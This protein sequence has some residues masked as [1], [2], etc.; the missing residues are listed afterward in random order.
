MKRVLVFGGAGFI[1]SYICRKLIEKGVTPIAFDSFAL[2]LSSLNPEELD[3]RNRAQKDRFEGIRDKLIP[4][5]GNATNYR[6][7]QRAIKIYDPDSII[8]L[9]GMPL[10]SA[11]NE[12]SEVSMEG[13]TSTGTIIQAIKDSG[14]KRKFIYT[15]SSTVYGDFGEEPVKEDREK[16]GK[17]IYA[18]VKLAGED[19]TRYF[20]RQFDIPYIII[21]P[22][23]VYGP[24]DINK[25]VVQKFI[26]GAIS[27]E[28]IVVNDPTSAI[29]FTYAKDAAQGFVLATLNEG[30]QDEEFNIS[31]GQG[32]TLEELLNIVRGHFPDMRFRISSS[33]PNL[34]RRG[35]A[36]ISKARRMLGYNPQYNLEKGVEEYIKYY[37]K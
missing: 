33:D 24:T 19:I 15:S 36:D 17:G 3:R 34:P 29:D 37:L 7:V 26:E 31:G 18:G 10:A 20:C 5:I 25:R 12:Y 1:G 11:A 2:Y 28:E 30:V 4:I 22:Q 13:V 14:R 35:S 27:G 21:R 6:E 23:G 8:H 32:R 9:A 16:R